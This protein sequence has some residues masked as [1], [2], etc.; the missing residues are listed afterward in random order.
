MHPVKHVLLRRYL[1]W[2]RE[3]KLFHQVHRLLAA[4]FDHFFQT[5]INSLLEAGPEAVNVLGVKQ[6]LYHASATH[7]HACLLV[8]EVW[9]ALKASAGC[10]YIGNRSIEQCVPSQNN[11]LHAQDTITLHIW[12]QLNIH[13]GI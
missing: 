11:A 10:M 8:C 4:T 12:A 2:N 9:A 7:K 5:L 13:D 1:G 3:S 6:G